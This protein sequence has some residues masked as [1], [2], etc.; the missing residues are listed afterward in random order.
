MA[1]AANLI[2]VAACLPGGRVPVIYPIISDTLLG[3][4]YL[5]YWPTLFALV[6][7]RAPARLRGVL[8]STVFFSLF[9]ANLV[10]GWLGSFYERQGPVDF[11]AMNAAIAAFGG[12]VAAGL[13]RPLARVLSQS[14]GVPFEPKHL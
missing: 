3:I 8:I 6:T 12:A 14:T 13:A 4:A 9:V 7:G 11:W 10:V 2:L 1:F 5:Y